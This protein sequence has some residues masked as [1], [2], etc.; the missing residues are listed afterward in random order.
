MSHD[1]YHGEAASRAARP[2]GD[3]TDDRTG[4]CSDEL[5]T[6]VKELT[7]NYRRMKERTAMRGKP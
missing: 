1:G 4:A 2:P 6:A 7:A 3:R 5:E